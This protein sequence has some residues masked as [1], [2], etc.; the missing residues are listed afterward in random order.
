MYS[1]SFPADSA[2]EDSDVV[3]ALLQLADEYL[4]ADLKQDLEYFLQFSIQKDNVLVLYENA[5]RCNSTQLKQLCM[6]FIAFNRES[7]STTVRPEDLADDIRA[8]VEQALQPQRTM[9]IRV[10]FSVNE[11][12]PLAINNATAIVNVLDSSSEEEPDIVET[13]PRPLSRRKKRKRKE[14]VP[15]RA[16]TDLDENYDDSDSSDD[17]YD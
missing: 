14:P 10:R 11:S 3:F 6:D 16:N 5:C 12:R 7:L 13:A 2:L 9:A 8:E 17:D 1:A 4:L 15:V